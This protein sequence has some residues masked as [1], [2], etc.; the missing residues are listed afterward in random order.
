VLSEASG[1]GTFSYTV[2]VIPSDRRYWMP[3]SRRIATTRPATDG[4]FS[5]R[6][7]PPGEYLLAAVA[8]VEPGGEFDPEFLSGVS[9][10]GLRVVVTE[11]GRHTQDI[12]VAR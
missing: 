6:D 7:L 8:D 11:G 3:G 12:R 1:V 2:V 5:F 9:A 10:A 4:R